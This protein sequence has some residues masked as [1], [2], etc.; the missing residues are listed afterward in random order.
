MSVNRF[1]QNWITR[2]INIS[3]GLSVYKSLKDI[4]IDRYIELPSTKIERTNILNKE[5]DIGDEIL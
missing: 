3:K 1:I 2:F 4:Q 5:I